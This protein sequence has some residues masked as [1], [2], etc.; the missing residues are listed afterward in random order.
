MSPCIDRQSKPK[1]EQLENFRGGEASAV[2]NRVNINYLH[3]E[4]WQSG[5]LRP[6]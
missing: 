1:C 3:L 5:R 4:R 2:E 6:T